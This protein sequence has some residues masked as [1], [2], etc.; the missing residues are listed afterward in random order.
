MD[1]YL[2]NSYEYDY[3]DNLTLEQNIKIALILFII[4]LIIYLKLY[5]F[6]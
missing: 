1:R 6:S 5:F 3:Y 2:F 4:G